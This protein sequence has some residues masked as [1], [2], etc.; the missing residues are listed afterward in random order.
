MILDPC[1]STAPELLPLEQHAYGVA[2][3]LREPQVF[4]DDTA[5]W[6]E[7]AAGLT[8]VSINLQRYDTQSIMCGA[9]F[10]YF[11]GKSIAA[12]TLLVEVTRFQFI[13][14]AFEAYVGDRL[15]H[16]KVTE[17]RNQLALFQEVLELP[18]HF[19]CAAAELKW[20]VSRSEEHCKLS[21][22]FSDGPLNPGLMLFIVSKMRNKMAHGALRLPEPRGDGGSPLPACALLRTAS[23]IVLFV[24]QMLDTI[25]HRDRGILMMYSMSNYEGESVDDYPYEKGIAYAH[26][27]PVWYD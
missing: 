5:T 2:Q 1:L 21:E 16:G 11:E 12:E 20:H 7:L 17:A 15:P 27:C 19:D 3:I 10:R 14:G 4:E 8:D 24:I 9:A 26:L 13:W 18:S 6:L 25:A 22:L 23:R